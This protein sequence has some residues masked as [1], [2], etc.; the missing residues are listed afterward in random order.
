MSQIAFIGLGRMGWPMAKNLVHAGFD[1]AVYDADAETL[2]KAKTELQVEVLSSPKDFTDRSIVI[3]MLP[4]SQIVRYI[5]CEWEGGI[6]NTLPPGATVVDMS[7]SNP[8]D[9]VELSTQAGLHEVV[10][11]DAPVS[12]GVA[13]AES[14]TL[15]IMH[16]G[17]ELPSDVRAVLLAMGDSVVLTGPIGSAHAMKALNNVVA[18]AATVACFEAIAAGKQFGLTPETMVEIWNSSTGQS[19][20]TSTVLPNHVLTGSYDSGFRLPLYAKD[21][22]VAASVFASAGIEANVA[23]AVTETFQEALGMLG[24]VDHTRLG[25]VVKLSQPSLP[26]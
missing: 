5:L 23:Q 22:E 20:V 24:D 7:S 16:G 13:R 19:F 17:L 10:M 8:Q 25:D 1:V 2:A 15:T 14:G 26:S 11:I 6:F 9:T 12:G 4:T 21:V 3:T 18:G